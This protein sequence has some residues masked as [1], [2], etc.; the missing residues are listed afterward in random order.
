MVLMFVI[1]AVLIVAAI[2][3]FASYVAE[4]EFDQPADRETDDTAEAI[5][6]DAT[7]KGDVPRPPASR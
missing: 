4:P 3:V 5:R 7:E 1:A 6:R 2:I